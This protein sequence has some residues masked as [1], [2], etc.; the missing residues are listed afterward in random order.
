MSRIDLKW[1]FGRLTGR[2][3]YVIF[4]LMKLILGKGYQ[5]KQLKIWFAW[6][7]VIFRNS[8]GKWVFLWLEL[9]WR[10]PSDWS[11]GE[12]R[13]TYYV[14]SDQELQQYY[15]QKERS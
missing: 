8:E 2:E 15:H 13:D 6:R 7:P 1:E 14:C 9:V 10:K 4:G 12:W 5:E 3:G 11:F